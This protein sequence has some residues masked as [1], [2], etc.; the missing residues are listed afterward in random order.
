[1]LSL[2]S[3]PLDVSAIAG[4]SVTFTVTASGDG[5]LSYQWFNGISAV[6]F[7]TSDTLT[8][9]SVT[10]ADSGDTFSVVV[11]D[12]GGASITSDSATLT[13]E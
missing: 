13:V 4:E 12:E 7:A 3:Q 11:S 10:L 5:A 2:V 1:L 8:L 6:R 9:S